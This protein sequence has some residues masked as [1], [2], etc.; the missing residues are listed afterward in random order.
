M[1]WWREHRADRRWA[2]AIAAVFER[3]D[4]VEIESV[5]RQTL[6]MKRR[7]LRNLALILNRLSNGILYPLVAILLLLL[8]GRAIL[9]AVAVAFLSVLL[10]HLIYPVTKRRCSRA[11]PFER[12][13]SIS[14]L[15][16]PLDKHSFPS[17]HAMTA[18]A[19]F[20]PL[21]AALPS[22]SPVAIVAVTMIGWARLAAG[23][24]YPS[25]I[26][27]GILLGSLTSGAGAIWLIQ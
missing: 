1:Q 7:H 20:L 17:G 6:L 26:A 13:S 3:L 9:A 23:H 16:R 19:A 24:H 18:T 12:D 14:S 21:S 25:D 5:R 15:L 8:V 10:A 4:L 27:A 2:D 11:R 22:L